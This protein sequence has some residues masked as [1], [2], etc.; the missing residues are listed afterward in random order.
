MELSVSGYRPYMTCATCGQ[1]WKTIEEF[2]VDLQLRTVGYTAD[3]VR[4]ENGEIVLSHVCSNCDATISI[5][6]GR[7][8]EWRRG[9]RLTELRTMSAE[10]PRF[11]LDRTNLEACAVRCSMGWVREVLQ[12]LKAHKIPEKL[13]EQ[14]KARTEAYPN[15]IKS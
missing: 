14:E 10:C 1:T 5:A 11:C 9:P 3:F 15:S 4:P 6:A 8:E 2:A 13:L 12:Y 7:F